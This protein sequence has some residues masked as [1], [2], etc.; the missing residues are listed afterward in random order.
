M[1]SFSYF[2][3][4][5]G[6]NVILSEGLFL[7]I[8]ARIYILLMYSFEGAIVQTKIVGVF[9]VTRLNLSTPKRFST[10]SKEK[11]EIQNQNKTSGTELISQ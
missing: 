2:S 5:S 1:T 7:H 6:V 3:T 10:S 11:R 8:A 9:T 4:V